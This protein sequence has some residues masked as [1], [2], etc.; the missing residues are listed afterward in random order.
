MEKPLKLVKACF[1]S[2]HTISAKV[3]VIHVCVTPKKDYSGSRDFLWTRSSVARQSR[4]FFERK[5][6]NN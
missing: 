6:S 4:A 2:E 3:C 5:L 1:E